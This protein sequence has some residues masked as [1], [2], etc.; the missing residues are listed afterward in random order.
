MEVTGFE[1]EHAVLQRAHPSCSRLLADALEGML[2]AVYLDSGR[3]L[4]AVD[5]FVC[6][7]GILNT[8]QQNVVL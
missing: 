5:A 3:S 1:A 6:K 8:I 2:G 4:T 7:I